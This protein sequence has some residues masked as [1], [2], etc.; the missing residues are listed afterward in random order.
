MEAKKAFAAC[1]EGAFREF[2]L[3]HDH[4]CVCP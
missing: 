3:G 4:G 1:D 2:D